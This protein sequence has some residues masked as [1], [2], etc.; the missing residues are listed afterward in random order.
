MSQPPGHAQAR[1]G[2]GRAANP[3]FLPAHCPV[4]SAPLGAQLRATRSCGPD[5]AVP[6]RTPMGSL[7]PP[8]Y[9]TP[10]PS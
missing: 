6:S 5:V 8:P 9:G 10:P 1:Q 3:P 2:C 4:P 7:A